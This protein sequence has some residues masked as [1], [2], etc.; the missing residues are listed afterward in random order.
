MFSKGQP[1]IAKSL[2]FRLA[3]LHSTI[4]ILSSTLLFAI[5]YYFL[6]SAL[7][8]QNHE[9]I[10]TEANELSARYI[11]SGIASIEREMA[12]LQ[13]SRK[14]EPFFIRVADPQNTTIQL[15]FPF[16]WAEFDL[17]KLERI[18]PEDDQWISI[19]AI[20]EEYSL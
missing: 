17:K 3:L 18:M 8:R 20:D 9:S 12:V 7:L 1:R 10:Q 6:S 14:R 11:S 2:W 13:K 4:F 16:Q 5:T 19:P 15:F